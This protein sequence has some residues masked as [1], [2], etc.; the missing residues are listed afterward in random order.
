[1]S[2]FHKYI[3]LNIDELNLLIGFISDIS[4]IPFCLVNSD[5]NDSSCIYELGI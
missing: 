1:M 2:P 5:K 3:L 4:T